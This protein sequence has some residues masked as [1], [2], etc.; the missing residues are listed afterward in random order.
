MIVSGARA[1]EDALDRVA[2]LLLVGER[3]VG[4]PLVGQALQLE[5]PADALGPRR[6]VQLPQREARHRQLARRRCAA[7]V[8]TLDHATPFFLNQASMR[9]QPS[10]A[11]ALR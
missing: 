8:E 6:E 3:L 9:F 7:S 10:S 2:E 5:H 11:S 4:A 1:G